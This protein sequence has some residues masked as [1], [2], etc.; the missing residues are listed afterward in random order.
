MK[1][2][3]NFLANCHHFKKCYF[4]VE[5][6]VFLKQYPLCLKSVNFWRCCFLLEKKMSIYAKHLFCWQMSEF[7][8]TMI[9]SCC[10]NFW[11]KVT[12]VPLNINFLAKL[13]ILFNKKT[14]K[15][16]NFGRNVDFS[17]KCPL[18]LKVIIF[19]QNVLIFWKMWLFL[20]MFIYINKLSN[21]G[22]NLQ[23]LRIY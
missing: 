6:F 21:S 20:W 12:S 4:L 18:L 5:I 8:S 7:S 3:F 10:A 16:R 13:S 22:K 19:L 1:Y 2:I 23:F 15:K 14:K 9:K 17:I 11:G